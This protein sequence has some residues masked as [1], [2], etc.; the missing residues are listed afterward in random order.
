MAQGSEYHTERGMGRGSVM[1]YDVRDILSI[2]LS[3]RSYLLT[4]E[5]FEILNQ[6]FG[7][8]YTDIG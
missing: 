4:R 6:W 1:P 7:E 2:W 3:P 5:D 8:V